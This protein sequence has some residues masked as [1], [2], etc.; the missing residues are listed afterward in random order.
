MSRLAEA[1]S[2][3]VDSAQTELWTRLFLHNRSG[4]ALKRLW[5][6][7]S[8]APETPERPHT[9]GTERDRERQREGV[10]GQ[11]EELM[12]KSKIAH[13]PID[14]ATTDAL[15]QRLHP[16]AQRGAERDKA[17]LQPAATSAR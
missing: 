17:R 6:L 7:P 3:A 12:A 5:S 1:H 14:R 9:A 13:R 10:R 2:T 4:D 11:V 8:P 16:P 15:I